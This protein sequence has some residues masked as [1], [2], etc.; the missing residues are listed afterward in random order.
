MVLYLYLTARWL[1]GSRIGFAS[2][3]FMLCWGLLSQP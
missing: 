2:A 3:C 1:S